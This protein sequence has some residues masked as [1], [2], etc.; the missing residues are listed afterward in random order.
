MYDNSDAFVLDLLDR[1][2]D[3]PAGSPTSLAAEQQPRAGAPCF[4]ARRPGG[5]LDP[6]ECGQTR[7][8]YT[9]CTIRPIGKISHDE[10]VH[11]GKHPAII[12]PDPWQRAQKHADARG[13]ATTTLGSRIRGLPA[14]L[15]VTGH[16]MCENRTRG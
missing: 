2:A 12:D 8:F 1:A 13:L 14:W 11:D 4:E 9:C 7:V 16:L 10:T 15:L 3:D 6:A 5:A